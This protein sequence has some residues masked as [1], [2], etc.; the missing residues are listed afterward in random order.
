MVTHPS[1]LPSDK[2]F[3]T[4]V[5]EIYLALPKVEERLKHGIPTFGVVGRA[6]FAN[7]HPHPKDGRRTLWFKAAPGVQADLV[8]EEPERLFVPPYVGPRGWVGLRLDID[9][10]WSEVA[11]IPAESWRL[12]DPKRLIPQRESR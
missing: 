4:G 10:N 3:L 8:G 5:R 1:R 9:L 12:T 2:E 11:K 7:L 6:A